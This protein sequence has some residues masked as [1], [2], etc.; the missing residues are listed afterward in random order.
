MAK[1][2]VKPFDRLVNERHSELGD[3]FAGKDDEKLCEILQKND[4]ALKA[5]VARIK[6]IFGKVSFAPP[7]ERIRACELARD[8]AVYAEKLHALL[9]PDSKQSTLE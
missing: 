1:Y 8:T 2:V 9:A 5:E 4:S 6:S 3:R 7:E